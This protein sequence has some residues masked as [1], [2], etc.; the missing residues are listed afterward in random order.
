MG[1]GRSRKVRMS[2]RRKVGVSVFGLLIGRRKVSKLTKAK[3]YSYIPSS[4]GP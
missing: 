3:S 2:I 1:T 4:V